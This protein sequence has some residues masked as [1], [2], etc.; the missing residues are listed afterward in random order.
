[1]ADPR[2]YFTPLNITDN[3]YRGFQVYI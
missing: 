1:M 3:P 2:C